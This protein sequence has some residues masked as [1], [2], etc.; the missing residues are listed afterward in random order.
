MYGD[1]CENR[2]ILTWACWGSIPCTCFGPESDNT[3]WRNYTIIDLARKFYY[4]WL[5]RVTL[6]VC[7]NDGS[8]LLSRGPR[9]SLCNRGG[10][11]GFFI[12][13]EPQPIPWLLRNNHRGSSVNKY[14]DGFCPKMLAGCR[15]L[16]IVV[17]LK[18]A[19]SLSGGD[20]LTQTL[21]IST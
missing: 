20:N 3:M 13:I 15:G 1:L 12:Y 9:W 17:L 11:R 6:V 4:W 10:Y 16:W 19:C 14:Q 8:Y 21:P 7:L 5:V 2:E 18:N